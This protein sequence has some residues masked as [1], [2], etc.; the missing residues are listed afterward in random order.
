MPSVMAW[1]DQSADEQRRVRELVRLF[2][3]TESRDEL[4]IGQIRDV[5]SNQLFPGTSVIQTRARY[6]LFVPWIF[7]FQQKKKRSG[8]DLLRRVHEHER[9]LIA[10]IRKHGDEVGL[11]GR[12]A[13]T[14]LKTLP[15]AIYWGGLQRFGIL[16]EPL[17]P[18]ELGLLSAED[19]LDAR[20]ERSHR[21]VTH[22]HPTM[23]EAPAGFPHE[24]EGGFVLR[25]EDAAWLRDRIVESAEG[26]LL[27]HL[28]TAEEPP[29]PLSAN[30]W[31][32]PVATSA[33]AGVQVVIDAAHR[34][35]LAMHGA[36]LLYNLLLAEAY[37]RAE[38]DRLDDRT[39]TYRDRLASWA[40][41]VDQ[42]RNLLESWDVAGWWDD[43]V[44]QNPRIGPRTKTFVES[45]VTVVRNGDLNRL[46][47][48]RDARALVADRERVQKK[49]QA[50]L[51]N[52]RLL[53]GWNGASGAAPLA[54]RW[55]TVRDL[56]TDVV[57]ALEVDDARA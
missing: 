10:E 6:L 42:N 25:P 16:S 43:I 31:S 49:G 55:G 46:A 40:D 33:P 53:A 39:E 26:T 7:Q 37:R 50:R 48:N 22:W 23:P 18:D 38:F 54:Y 3:D 30:P 34:F 9:Y 44:E 2:A 45:W 57:S 11:I 35:S 32:D 21:A 12:D 36:S 15:S 47:D 52:H 8:P 20:H 41:E 19:D 13:G 1:L 28:V 24:V 56:V 4:G 29:S 14:S 27:A 5:F 17:A 51:P